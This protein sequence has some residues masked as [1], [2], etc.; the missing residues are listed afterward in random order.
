MGNKWVY[1]FKCRGPFIN[2]QRACAVRVTVV[3]FVCLSVKSHLTSGASVHPE[4]DVTCSTGNEGQKN[5]GVFSETAP[6]RRFS[7]LSVV[8]PYVQSAIF[9]VHVLTNE[10]CQHAGRAR[11]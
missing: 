8:R 6:L 4:I 9:K 3:G 5:C 1:D 11:V 7:T 2:P 10:A